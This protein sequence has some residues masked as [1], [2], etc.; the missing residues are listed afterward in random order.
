[1]RNLGSHPYIGLGDIFF[2]EIPGE[3]STAPEA[4][5][6][7]KKGTQGDIKSQRHHA[8]SNTCRHFFIRGELRAP[9]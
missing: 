2:P 7:I 3:E 9:V 6:I 1:M 4:F 8:F 5:F